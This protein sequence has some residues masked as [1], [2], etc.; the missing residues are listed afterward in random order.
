MI[1]DL[2]TLILI[3]WANLGIDAIAIIPGP[4]T[5]TA[6]TMARPALFLVREEIRRIPKMV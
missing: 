5:A 4:A 6:R 2:A 3:D 1:R